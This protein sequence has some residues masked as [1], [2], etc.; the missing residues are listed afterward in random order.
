MV[1]HDLRQN[2]TATGYSGMARLIPLPNGIHSSRPFCR[3][4][5]SSG[6]G[7]SVDETTGNR[8]GEQAV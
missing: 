6:S 2:G 1:S 4:I 7:S 5:T 3:N 8:V